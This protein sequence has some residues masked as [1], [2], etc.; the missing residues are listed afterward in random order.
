MNDVSVTQI[1][2]RQKFYRLAYIL[3][4]ITILYNLLEGIVSIF[5]G[6][7]DETLSLFG[8]GVDSFV[9]VMSG[10]GIYYMITKLI[11]N[12]DEKI[13]D[14]E[15]QA[16]MITGIA[17]YILTAGLLLTAASNLFSNHHP[18]TTFWGIVISLISISTMQLLIFYKLKVGRALKSDAIIADANC[19]K[20][21]LYLSVILLF[22]SIG[23]EI[24]KIG[25][26]DS[27]GAILIAY[28]AF[29]EGRE[30]FEKAKG[31][32]CGCSHDSCVKE[33]G[34]AI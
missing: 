30:S 34:K 22:S 6:L 28:F 26:I 25:T 17:F 24:F 1:T 9:E 15:K 4:V 19:T 33:S 21:C 29:K 27:I 10:V 31:K 8:F 12:G 7:E 13:D 14:F 3:A 32:S 16:L 20:T 18:K 2:D 23:Y 11:N 5:F